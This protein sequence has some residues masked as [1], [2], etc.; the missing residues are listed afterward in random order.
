M[1]KLTIILISFLFITCK[2]EKKINYAVISGKIENFKTN[3]VLITNIEG[4]E[5]KKEMSVDNSGFFKDTLYIKP[6]YYTF[7]SN[8]EIT[9]LYL[10]PTYNLT[11][12]VNVDK[13][14]ETL[15]YSGEGVENNNYLAAKTLKNT[16]SLLAVY[17]L[18]KLDESEFLKELYK[19][20]ES[21]EKLLFDAEGLTER[22]K[23][24]EVRN[25]DYLKLWFQTIY[26]QYHCAATNDWSFRVSSDFM[27]PLEDVD[28][29]NENDYDK[30]TSYKIL[31]RT[32][33]EYE[34]DNKGI[35][36]F[37]NR[38]KTVHSELI[39]NEIVKE[40][41]DKINLK[42]DNN[43]NLYASLM[44]ASTDS[45]FKNDLTQR[46]NQLVKVEK[47]RTSPKFFN[48]E[49]YK[50]K[51]MSLDDFKGK[52]IYLDIWETNCGWCIKEF[53]AFKKLE[54]EYKNQNIAFIGISNELGSR[55]SE[56]ESRNKWKNMI[57]KK[58]L[59]G[60]QLLSPK[61][62]KSQFMEEYIVYILPRYI[63]I[64]PEGNIV[65]SD[66]PKPSDPNLKK[67]FTE[68]GM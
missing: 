64:D 55:F 61:G 23:D 52:Y 4:E 12:N 58:N 68:L 67:I 30:L 47:G 10:E 6:G 28:F 26:Q 43:T 15:N 16:T 24:L 48:Y 66:A 13:F 46:Y 33:F 42:N 3:S 25:L 2:T 65:D 17:P 41:G 11:L 49:R 54:K 5:F 34:L 31:T 59:D 51:S 1:K 18:Y 57:E 32:Y 40:L 60:I 45:V 37:E 19:V 8:K 9:T 53:P 14:D 63:I 56:K 39:R 29:N 20:T 7:K 27:N 50:G 21:N 36:S 22:F 62:S 35:S 44:K 38:L